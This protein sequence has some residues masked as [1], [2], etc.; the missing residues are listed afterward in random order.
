MVKNGLPWEINQ[1]AAI[2][3]KIV[4]Y[5]LFVF[6]KNKLYKPR[7]NGPQSGRQNGM[8]RKPRDLVP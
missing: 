4:F 8:R 6:K 2:N 5:F 3:P 7:D 1:S